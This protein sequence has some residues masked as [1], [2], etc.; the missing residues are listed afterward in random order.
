MKY[1]YYIALFCGAIFFAY[2]AGM[3]V[4]DSN[5]RAKFASENSESI[6]NNTNIMEQTNEQV[7]HTG[8]RDIRRILRERYTIAE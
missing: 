5:C 4:G 8:T 1:M 7:F 3:R 2:I 6:I